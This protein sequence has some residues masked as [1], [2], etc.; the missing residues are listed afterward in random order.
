MNLDSIYVSDKDSVKNY[1]TPNPESA[2]K[3][4][5]EELRQGPILITDMYHHDERK[6]TNFRTERQDHFETDYVRYCVKVAEEDMSDDIYTLDVPVGLAAGLDGRQSSFAVIDQWL[7]SELGENHELLSNGV[8]KDNGGDAIYKTDRE[9]ANVVYD[10]I[11][12]GRFRC[13]KLVI[14]TKARTVRWYAEKT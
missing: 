9:T 8:V 1:C 12:I 7:K 4:I 11:H 10:M 6:S 14:N 3:A 2:V 13:G 5:I